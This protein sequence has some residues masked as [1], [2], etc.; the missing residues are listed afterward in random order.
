VLVV[1][2]TQYFAKQML[3]FECIYTDARVLDNEHGFA[4]LV[5][6]F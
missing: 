3:V 5:V 2:E 6:A 1:G 4:K